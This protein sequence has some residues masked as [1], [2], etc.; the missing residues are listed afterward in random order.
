MEKQRF[1]QFT[2]LPLLSKAQVLRQRN[3]QIDMNEKDI[4]FYDRE[5]TLQ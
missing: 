3:I 5:K 4:D 2:V 1:N